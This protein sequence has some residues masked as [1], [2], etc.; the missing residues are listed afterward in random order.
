MVDNIVNGLVVN[1]V[2]QSNKSEA[3]TTLQEKSSEHYT[4]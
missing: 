3:A 1:A 2:Q 4:T